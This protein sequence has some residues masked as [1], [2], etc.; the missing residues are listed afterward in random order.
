MNA[1]DFGHCAVPGSD[2][3][4][5]RLGFG[6]SRL[7]AGGELRASS[8]ILEAALACGIRHFDTA[9][10]YSGG[11]SEEVLGAVLSGIRDVTI[12]TKVGITGD[13]ITKPSLL[14]KAYR[15]GIR[16]LLARFPAVKSKLLSLRNQPVQ[17]APESRPAA[18]PSRIL[19]RDA[20]LR[21][22]EASLTRL[23]R[24]SLDIL[25]IHE[26]D[27]I[28]LDEA[29]REV[30]ENLKT[31]G[32]IKAFGVG[33]G[34]AVQEPLN[35]GQII[36]SGFCAPATPESNA[37]LS[38]LPKNQLRIWHGILRQPAAKAPSESHARI[39]KVLNTFPEAAVIFSASSARQITQIAT[40]R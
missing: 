12:T 40:T 27:S 22:V 39:S 3:K 20:V 29:L 35:F 26:S 21:S 19:T 11:Q 24:S 25:L 13:A 17:V 16:P 15:V 28:V 1:L 4:I 9:P 8:R 2:L 34:R 6:A 10:S 37:D 7:F 36:Q 30:F 33:L 38:A 18:A 31:Q 5:G 23:R 32:M 14:S